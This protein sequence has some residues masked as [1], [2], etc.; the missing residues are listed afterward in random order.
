MTHAEFIE[1]YRAGSIRVDIDRAAAAR[2]VSARLLLPLVRLPVLGLGVALALLGWLWTGFGV[3]AMGTIAPIIIKRS[4]R[5]FVITQ[6]L[7]DEKFY[8]EVVS[9][10]LLE[11]CYVV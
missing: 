4:A 11:V 8:N 10:G 3:I 7:E 6:A 9:A 1:G 5:H 2:H